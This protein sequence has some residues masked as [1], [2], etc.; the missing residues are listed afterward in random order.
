MKT[1]LSLIENISIKIS[2]LNELTAFRRFQFLY[3]TKVLA[4]FIK[5][6]NKN[7]LFL[8][9]IE[10][11]HQFHPKKGVV[12]AGNHRSFFD[13]IVTM[14]GLCIK[15]MEWPRR[16]S[17]PVRSNFFYDNFLGILFN[18]LAVGGVLYPPFFRDNHKKNWNQDALD[19]IVTYLS[20][21]GAVIG[22]HPEGTRGKD[23]DP[24]SLSPSKPGIGQIM[25]RSQP[26]VIPF[27]INGLPN[28]VIKCAKDNWK[29]NPK[30]DPIIVVYGQPIDYSQYMTME[31]SDTLY[32]QLS[33]DVLS[34]IR[35]LMPREK[36]IRKACQTGEIS[37]NDPRW[38]T[39]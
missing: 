31:P 1:Q 30:S 26:V 17:F 35:A 7:R 20:Y 32:R 3:T 29:K 6:L 19:R 38:V 36:E 10:W 22:M 34:E 12:F 23:P 25:L 37:I 28:S 9:N 15:K 2:R 24:Y 39:T 4:N 33:E 5:Q 11:M 27:F 8:D 14:L 13:L 16:Y 21:Q 18:Y